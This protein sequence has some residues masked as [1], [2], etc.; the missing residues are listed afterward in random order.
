MSRV[1]FASATVRIGALSRTCRVLDIDKKRLLKSVLVPLAP[2]LV[3]VTAT[4][5]NIVSKV[6][7]FVN[8]LR[9]T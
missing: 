4:M 9:T 2:A 8:R 6:G 7:G 1:N 3:N 5:I